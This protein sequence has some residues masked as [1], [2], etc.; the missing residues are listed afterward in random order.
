MHLQGNN[1]T[2]SVDHNPH[3]LPDAA[4]NFRQ[5]KIYGMKLPATSVEIDGAPTTDFNNSDLKT[6]IIDKLS[7]SVLEPHTVTWL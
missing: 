7:I 4:L 1:L 3:D 5:I 6:L 2:L